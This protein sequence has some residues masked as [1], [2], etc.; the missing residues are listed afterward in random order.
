M[1]FRDSS[2]VLS[3]NITIDSTIPNIPMRLL[4][5]EKHSSRTSFFK[6]GHVCKGPL[7]SLLII[8]VSLGTNHRII[9]NKK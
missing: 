4:S 5:E 9:L 8:F 3:L 7:Y 2:F 1:R 6:F